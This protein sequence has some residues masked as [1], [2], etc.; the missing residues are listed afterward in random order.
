MAKA[1]DFFKLVRSP[2]LADMSC[3][4]LK[5]PSAARSSDRDFFGF[6]REKYHKQ[7]LN[8]YLK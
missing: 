7:S 4:S 1:K 2:R 5:W 3:K 8:N 6:L